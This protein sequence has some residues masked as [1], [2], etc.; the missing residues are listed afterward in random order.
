MNTIVVNRS[1]TQEVDWSLK[2]ADGL[3][4]NLVGCTLT[5]LVGTSLGFTADKITKAMSIVDAANGTASAGL[6]PADTSDLNGDYFYRVKLTMPD[7]SVKTAD[8]GTFRVVD[9]VL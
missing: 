9:Q 6:T 2:S 7:G 4:Y 1:D 8:Y 3:A 5:L